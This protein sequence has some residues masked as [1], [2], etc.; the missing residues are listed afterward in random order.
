MISPTLWVAT[1]CHFS[2]CV[3]FNLTSSDSFFTVCRTFFRVASSIPSY[4][5]AKRRSQR[6]MISCT[7]TGA[8]HRCLLMLMSGTTRASY[9]PR[10]SSLV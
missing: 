8:G 1:P 10:M 4:L 2:T 3:N 5:S 7:F 6:V 9:V